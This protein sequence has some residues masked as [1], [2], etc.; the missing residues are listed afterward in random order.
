MAYASLPLRHMVATII[1]SYCAKFSYSEKDTFR[2]VGQNTSS[3]A[4]GILS[5]SRKTRWIQYHDDG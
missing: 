4:L 5:S 1:K 2:R 3:K